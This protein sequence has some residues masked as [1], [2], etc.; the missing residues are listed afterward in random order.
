L[1]NFNKIGLEV[2]V[3]PMVDVS[4]DGA[5]WQR[6]RTFGSSGHVAIEGLEL[7]CD[8]DLSTKQIPPTS[9]IVSVKGSFVIKLDMKSIMIPWKI[10]GKYLVTIEKLKRKLIEISLDIFG[11]WNL[12]T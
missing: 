12:G 10:M 11:V 9:F 8:L 4:L 5:K 6:V 7:G 1:E 2:F 3:I